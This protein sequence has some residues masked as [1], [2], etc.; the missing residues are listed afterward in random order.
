MPAITF[1]GNIGKKEKYLN[2]V[3]FIKIIRE[4]KFKNN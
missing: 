2:K 4:L 1:T 3:L